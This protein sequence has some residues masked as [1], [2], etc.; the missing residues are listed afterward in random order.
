MY[1]ICFCYAWT[2]VDVPDH[3]TRVAYWYSDGCPYT[4]THSRSWYTRPSEHPEACTLDHLKSGTAWVWIDHC[5]QWRECLWTTFQ[6]WVEEQHKRPQRVGPLAL[7]GLDVEQK[8]V[9]THR[10]QDGGADVDGDGL[11][12]IALAW[13]DFGRP[14]VGVGRAVRELQWH[15]LW[16][17]AFETRTN[18]LDANYPLI[19]QWRQNSD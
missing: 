1:F 15:P 17:I 7:E 12:M 10:G 13:V 3:I 8:M 5:R 11:R 16:Y 2:A 14:D 19:K 18:I 4:P 9:Q 6:P